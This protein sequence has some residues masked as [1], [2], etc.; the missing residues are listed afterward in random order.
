MRINNNIT[1]TS[2]KG[3]NVNNKQY[4]KEDA[5][6]SKTEQ[7]R[8]VQAEQL[9]NLEQQLKLIRETQQQK[10]V[11]SYTLI[12][13]EAEKRNPFS[14]FCLEH[15]FSTG[16]DLYNDK[17]HGIEKQDDILETK[18]LYADKMLSLA[19]STFKTMRETDKK[20]FTKAASYPS[21]TIEHKK[22]KG[23]DNIAGYKLEKSVLKNEFTDKVK[24]EKE[25]EDINIFGSILFF[26]PFENGK[27]YI[28]ENI[29]EETECNIS[30]L[31][32]AGKKGKNEFIPKLYDI[33]QKSEEDFNKDR[34][35]TIIFIDEVDRALRDNQENAQQFE[36]FIKTCSKKYHCTVF[37]ATNDPL[38]L[39]LNMKDP[40]VFPVK[41]SIDP[42]DKENTIELFKYYIE[43]YPH[44]EIDYE[45][46][47]KNVRV[48]EQETKSKFSNALIENICS[49]SWSNRSS[50]T[51]NQKDLH[52][53]IK[54]AVPTLTIELQKKFENDYNNLIAE[55]KEN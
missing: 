31:A 41:M 38:D 6:Q 18:S 21:A 45:E 23:M 30:E 35:R 16:K 37:A 48:R 54:N 51:L 17:K 47:E 2:F 46:L 32:I 14:K 49:E 20:E 50:D 39:N 10:E 22:T 53:T 55:K 26:G 44:E 36:D 15:G 40:E 5:V 52:N 29:A 3:I 13:N 33:A 4:N 8:P 9:K 7:L 11:K 1:I 43:D 19:Y 34:T 25:G 27:T 28:T 24:R 12:D 42:P